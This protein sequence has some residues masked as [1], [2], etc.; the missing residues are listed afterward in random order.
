M[1]TAFITGHQSKHIRNVG[2]L[3]PDYTTRQ[4]R[5]QPSSYSLLG[6]L[7]ILHE[8]NVYEFKIV[9][10]RQLCNAWYCM[11]WWTKI[12]INCSL[13][14]YQECDKK[15]AEYAKTYNVVRGD[16]QT[17]C[18]QLGIQGQKIKHELVDLLAELPSI[19]RKCADR[20]KTLNEAVEF[21][22]EFVKFIF[23]GEHSGGCVPL[24]KYMIGKS[25]VQGLLYS[26]SAELRQ[27]V[28][29]N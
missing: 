25:I 12:K 18:E 23:G 16:F 22:A 5:R 13:I 17:L 27:R 4:S 7:Q 8:E 9:T 26:Q 11:N 15:E 1:L 10:W 14:F 29:S 2:K 24:L 19:Y 20:V 6:Q 3:P 21:Y 28:L